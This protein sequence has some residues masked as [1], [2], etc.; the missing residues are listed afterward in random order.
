[1]TFSNKKIQSFHFKVYDK[2]FNSIS[3]SKSYTTHKLAQL[4]TKKIDFMSVGALL[5]VIKS[6][7]KVYVTCPKMC[8]KWLYIEK[9]PQKF[10]KHTP[11]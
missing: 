11:E 4:G 7:I 8:D 6:H 5:T 1:M 2:K 3:I 10:P 9:K